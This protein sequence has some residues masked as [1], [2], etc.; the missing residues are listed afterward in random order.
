ME[1][2]CAK[3]EE[4]CGTVVLAEETLGPESLSRFLEA[5][6]KQPS[7][8]DIPVI[9]ITGGGEA[10]QQRLRRLAATGPASNVALLERPFHPETLLSTVEVAM[11]SRRRQY[12]VRDLLMGQK[13]SELRLQNIL[14]SISDAFIALDKHWRF[15]YVNQSYMALVSPLY[16]SPGNSS[17]TVVWEKFPDIAGTEVGRFLRAGDGHAEDGGH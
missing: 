5:L 10:I 1:Q 13:A 3:M 12:Q 9:I 15:T 2:V 4:G 8:S 11:R 14:E 16:Y 6:R 7:W 17:A